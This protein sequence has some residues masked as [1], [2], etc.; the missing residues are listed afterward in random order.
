MA[1]FQ[2]LVDLVVCPLAES[3]RPAGAQG[4]P[5]LRTA[6]FLGTGLPGGE[7][8]GVARDV[9]ESIRGGEETADQRPGI[10]HAVVDGLFHVWNGRSGQEAVVEVLPEEPRNPRIVIDDA[11]AGLR[12]T[13]L[14]F[15]AAANALERVEQPE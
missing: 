12:S 2:D 8:H 10:D 7:P 6:L 4:A 9:L 14:L 3:R 15:E 5:A 11:D 13:A 1:L